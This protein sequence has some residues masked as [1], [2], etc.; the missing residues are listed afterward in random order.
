MQKLAK[1][2]IKKYEELEQR[3]EREKELNIVAQKLEV[4]KQLMVGSLLCLKI[5]LIVGS[6]EVLSL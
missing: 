5:Y 1:K 4:K 3:I 6:S 2:K